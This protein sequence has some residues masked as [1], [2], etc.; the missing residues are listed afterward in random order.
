MRNWQYDGEP[1]DFVV[2]DKEK[3]IANVGQTITPVYTGEEDEQILFDIH[4]EKDAALASAAPDM[5]IVL[6]ELEWS[7]DLLNIDGEMICS[8]C[9]MCGGK[10]H[11]GHNSN[12]S[13]NKA[14]QKATTLKFNEGK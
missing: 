3:F 5:Y 11:K 9:P 14:L 1:G 13:L 8:T 4:E 10:E 12:C 6:K 2:W 7:N